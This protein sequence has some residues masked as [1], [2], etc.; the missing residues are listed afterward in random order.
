[1]A[2]KKTISSSIDIFKPI[3]KISKRFHLTLFFVFI[4]ACLTGAVLLINYTLKETANDPE[5]VSP[6]STSTVDQAT[7]NRIE[8]YHA[9]SETSSAPV[10]PAG[11]VN[12]V[13]E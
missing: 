10:L 13:G 12:P 2:K 5:Y 1:M 3:R 8:T 6:I 11:R 7:L 9:S 4:V